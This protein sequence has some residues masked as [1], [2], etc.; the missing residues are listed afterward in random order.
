MIDVR[1]WFWLCVVSAALAGCS[2][3]VE[4]EAVAEKSLA[5]N[6]CNETVPANRS[7]DGLPAYAQCSGVS[8]GSI[9]SNNGIDTSTTS[10][11]SDWVLTQRGGGYQCTE[12]A[13]R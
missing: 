7:V 8:S 11:G 6:A 3:P 2:A 13:F 10:M 9:Y 12:W 1:H 5:L 4:D